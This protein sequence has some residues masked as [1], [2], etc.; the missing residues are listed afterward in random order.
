MILRV[1]SIFFLAAASISAKATAVDSTRKI[2]SASPVE[3]FLRVTGLS[4]S[5]VEKYAELFKRHDIELPELLHLSLPELQELGV[6]PYGNAAKISTISSQ[7]T[8]Q[9][10]GSNPCRHGGICRDGFDCFYC[11]CNSEK[12]FYGPRCELPC[13]CKNSARCLS[14]VTGFQCVCQPGWRGELCD[15]QWLDEQVCMEKNKKCDGCINE[16]GGQQI[17][18]ISAPYPNSISRY[19][20]IPHIITVISCWYPSFP[21][22]HIHTKKQ[23]PVCVSLVPKFALPSR[24]AFLY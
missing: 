23:Y 4:S 16:S 7:D 9:C 13:R 8:D 15:E 18:I 5:N 19:F 21:R 17:L 10:A 6:A 3:D 2:C 1:L 24:G 14:T 20:S 11:V 12:G 22:T